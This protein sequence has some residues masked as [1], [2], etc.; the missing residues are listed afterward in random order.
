M[1][2]H[3]LNVTVDYDPTMITQTQLTDSL[4]EYFHGLGQDL[5]SPSNSDTGGYMALDWGYETA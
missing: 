4:N 1:K 5:N 2:K 3:T